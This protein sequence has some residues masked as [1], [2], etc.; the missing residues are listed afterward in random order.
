MTRWIAAAV[1]IVAAGIGGAILVPSADAQEAKS[2]GPV[3]VLETEERE[4]EVAKDGWDVPDRLTLPTYF[5]WRSAPA[6]R[7]ALVAGHGQPGTWQIVTHEKM[8]LL[9]NTAS[10]DT[11]H[12]RE[13]GVGGVKWEPIPRPELPRHDVPSGFGRFL[14]PP[15]AVQPDRRPEGDLKRRIEERRVRE[16]DGRADEAR[17]GDEKLADFEKAVDRIESELEQI[18]KK[19]NDAGPEERAKLRDQRR[20]LEKKLDELERELRDMRRGR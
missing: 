13:D 11:F 17:D 2:E 4:V 20:E 18:A 9:L 6:T 19:L 5:T 10:G 3:V 15:D 14:P 12:L 1:A 7:T 16:K 8:V